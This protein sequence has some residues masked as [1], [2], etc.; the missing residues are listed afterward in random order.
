M[1]SIAEPR[2][3]VNK[4][5]CLLACDVLAR[6]EGVRD[7]DEISRL[8]AA[9]ALLGERLEAMKSMRLSNCDVCSVERCVVVRIL[10]VHPT[11]VVSPGCRNHH[12]HRAVEGQA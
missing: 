3:L 5:F 11:A 7:G 4:G 8:S 2:P 10:D 9:S 12:H 1:Y 6:E